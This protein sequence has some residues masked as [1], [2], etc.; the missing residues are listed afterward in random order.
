MIPAPDEQG[1]IP[2][3]YGDRSLA[4]VLPAVARA[5]GAPHAMADPPFLQDGLGEDGLGLGLP[6][7][8]RYVVFLIDGLGHELLVDHAEVAPYLTSLLHSSP[9]PATAGVPTTTATSL[10]SLGT[11]APPGT[12]GVLGFTT[13]I[14][15]TDQLLN[16][17]KWSGKVDP[18]QWQPQQT[19]FGRLA[20]AGVS[21]TVV[22]K[23]EFAGSGLTVASCR[24]AAFVG[25]D[26]LGERVVAVRAASQPAPSVTYMYE[27]DL[28]WTGHRYGVASEQWETQLSMI[29]LAA[30][31]LR[32]ALPDQVRLL[33]VAD[34]GMVDVGP[35]DRLEVESRPEL[36]D[37]VV[38]VGG[39]ARFRHVYCR[40][41]ADE[42]LA[43]TWRQVLGSDALV[44]TRDEAVARGWF[45]PVTAPARMRIGDV[46]V[47]CTGR[48]ALLTS[49]FPM[50]S[51]LIGMHGS[52]TSAEMLIP[53]LV[54]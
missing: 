2:P 17:F 42:D 13:R 30:E 8:A 43:A 51:R 10:T 12:H 48:R 37:G 20:E 4:D 46:V 44:L 3:A 16:A 14:P 24:G 33:V 6:E 38:L 45:G 29:D 28:D 50:E 11:G 52:L 26:R 53:L 21:A 32:E 31:R 1:F 9:A 25:A 41:G 36:M 15:G 19:G 18:E 22:N 49:T 35:E 7:A 5:V 47:A 39:E 40:S 27:G 34:H 54:A 23:R